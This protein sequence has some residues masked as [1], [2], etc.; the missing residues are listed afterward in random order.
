MDNYRI[1]LTITGLFAMI[2]LI[3]IGGLI[4]QGL[5]IYCQRI[6][7]ETNIAAENQMGVSK[8]LQNSKGTVYIL[9]Q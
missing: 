6:Q 3:L 2:V 1:L 5:M 9:G 7:N 4:R 8:L